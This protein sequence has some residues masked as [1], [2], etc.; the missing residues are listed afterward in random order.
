LALGRIGG[1]N[2]E[3]GSRQESLRVRAISLLDRC[4][5]GQQNSNEKKQTF[6]RIH[7][8]EQKTANISKINAR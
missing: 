8:I 6:R 5:T 7:S 1:Q 2:L 4:T 3:S